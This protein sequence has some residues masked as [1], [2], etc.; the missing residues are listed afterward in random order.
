MKLFKLLIFISLLINI[1]KSFSLNSKVCSSTENSDKTCNRM[2][3]AS[4]TYT[5]IVVG[6]TG[7]TGRNVVKQLV[8]DAIRCNKVVAFSRSDITK[9]QYTE[10]FPGI[11]EV[12]AHKKLEIRKVNYDNLSES[13]FYVDGKASN[14]L[15]CCLGT[16]RKG[17]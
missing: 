5:A 15:F 14:A 16:T 17:K 9:Q 8:N 6:A 1:R 12:K 11:D 3:Q 4:S 7:A 2:A 10:K 13:E